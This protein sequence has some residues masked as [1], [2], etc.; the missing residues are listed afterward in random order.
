MKPALLAAVA[1]LAVLTAPWL[2]AAQ[3]APAAADPVTAGQ[4]IAFD[5]ARGNCLA[6]H[7]IAGG[8]AMGNVGPALRNMKQIMPDPKQ[9]YAVI[10]NE[11]AR[12]PQTVMPAFGRNG[13]L[14]KDEINDVVAYLYTK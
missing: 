6:C 5:R 1:A 9:L 2:A 4:A 14:T 7:V 3:T 11:Q 13:I 12:N 10:Y 8:T